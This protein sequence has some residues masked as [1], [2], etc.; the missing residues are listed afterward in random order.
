MNATRTCASLMLLLCL[1]GC[2]A[3]L[4]RSSVADEFSAAPAN[5]NLWQSVAA[6]RQDDW[7]HLLNTGHQAL[8][9]RIRAI[10]SASE[11]IDLQTFLWKSDAT[12]KLIM[13]RLLAAADR[14]VAI[15]ILLDDSFLAGNDSDVTLLASHPQI[16]YRIYNP[17]TQRAHSQPSKQLANLTDFQ[18]LN[19]R[20]HKKVMIVDERAA[21]V[22]GRNL[23]DEYF[24]YHQQHNFRDMEVL[25][26]GALVGKIG[27]EFDRYWNNDWSIPASRI[28]ETP[29]SGIALLRQDLAVN[30]LAFPVE[31]AETQASRWRN[32]VRHAHCGKA[33]LLYDT[34]PEDLSL[35]ENQAS[36]LAQQLLANLASVER[37]VII[38]SAYYIPTAE[39]EARVSS[40]E[41]RGVQV[42]LLTNSLNTNNHTTA[43]SAYQKHRKAM[44]EAGADLHETRADAEDRSLYMEA[45]VDG[46]ILGLHAKTLVID[47]DQL[48]IGSTN[49]DPRSLRI[50]TEIG[51]WIYSPGLNHALRQQLSIDM[52]PANAWHLALDDD[53]DLVW[54]SEQQTLTRQPA[55]SFYLRMENWFFGLLPIEGEM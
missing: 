45:P 38:V 52:L 20:M 39:L 54:Q 3:P 42:R 40:M 48:F 1:F 41:Q 32:M 47:D 53:D 6:M 14:G 29:D 13:A 12:G 31:D 34:P 26:G 7:F 55:S 2:A 46:R 22:G 49:F 11:S 16:S 9:W 50:N 5:S 17:A 27:V 19:H 30:A 51:L 8:A 21:I 10:D 35:A 4:Q 18:R 25:T 44:L 15:R 33:E 36:Q 37:E 23:A 43:H 24:G 28:I